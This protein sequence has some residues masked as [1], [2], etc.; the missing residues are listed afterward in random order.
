MLPSWL[1]SLRPSISAALI[2]KPSAEQ[3]WL[4][5]STAA[6]AVPSGSMSTPDALATS[7]DQLLSSRPK[8]SKKWLPAPGGIA[9][10]LPDSVARFE[11]LQW[12]ASLMIP[13][14]LRQF[15]IERFE[16]VNQSVREGWAVHA[17]WTRKDA[18]TLAYAV[19]HGVLDALHGIVQKHGLVLDRVLP[20]SALA[21]YGQLGLMN[22]NELRIM[23]GGSSTC[24]LLYANGKLVNYLMETVRGSASDSLKRLIS[25]LQM[26][27]LSSSVKLDRLSLVGTDPIH[28]K[29]ILDANKPTK[30]RVVNPMRWGQWQ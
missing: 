12:T 9:V 29:E 17:E 10:I 6:W 28:L 27:E 13:D 22:H 5:K 19:P 24:A 1:N 11:L 3:R 26:S 8:T 21:H 2:D 4:G 15:A 23:Q 18:N 14:E 20:L 16:M 30:I 25:R 7:L